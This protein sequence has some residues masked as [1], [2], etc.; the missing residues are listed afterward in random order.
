MLWVALARLGYVPAPGSPFRNGGL[1]S[2]RADGN[3][4][5]ATPKNTAEGSSPMTAVFFNG[6]V[7]RRVGQ[8]PKKRSASVMMFSGHHV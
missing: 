1:Y 8:A 3:D 5:L 4:H 7:W 6:H 2:N